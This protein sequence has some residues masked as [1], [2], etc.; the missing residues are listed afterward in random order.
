MG[1]FD[2]DGILTDGNL[3]G[4][5]KIKI[6]T[7]GSP[8][9]NMADAIDPISIVKRNVFGLSSSEAK[10][11]LK[12]GDHIS[13]QRVGYTHHGI[14]IGHG[15][16]IH[17]LE[18]GVREDSLYDF[19]DGYNIH[20]EDTPRKYSKKEVVKRAQSRL[21]ENDYNVLWE[22]C[23]QFAIWCRTGDKTYI[24]PSTF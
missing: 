21:Y 20:I 16:V 23:E 13:V 24:S 11:K 7:K 14:Y 9:E 12:K 18:D 5:P 19:A 3:T 2:L 15:R 6:K 8:L 10:T 4:M 17:Y 22:N 1:L